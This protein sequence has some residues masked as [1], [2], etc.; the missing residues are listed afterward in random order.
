MKKKPDE[1]EGIYIKDTKSGKVRAIIGETYSYAAKAN[2]RI[3]W[4]IY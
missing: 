1:N 4:D 3:Y 2:Y